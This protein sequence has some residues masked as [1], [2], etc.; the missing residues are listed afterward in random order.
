MYV[1]LVQRL[2]LVVSSA[3]LS[4]TSFSTLVVVSLRTRHTVGAQEVWKKVNK[5]VGRE[6][7]GSQEKRG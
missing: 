7:K 1:L 3:A 6:G 2:Y 4:W 5:S